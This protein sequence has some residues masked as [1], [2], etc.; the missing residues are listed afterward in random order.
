MLESTYKQNNKEIGCSM[1]DDRLRDNKLETEHISET[2]RQ[3]P[4]QR[5]LRKLAHYVWWIDTERVIRQEPLRVIA[6]AMRYANNMAEYRL[7]YEFGEEI[8]KAVLTK[9]QAGWFDEK[10][11]NF[12]HLVLY[13]TSDNIPTLPKRRFA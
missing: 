8:L 9:A 5:R 3:A 10:N 6:N 2:L 12:W 4:Y 13:Y 1:R 11:W 7:L